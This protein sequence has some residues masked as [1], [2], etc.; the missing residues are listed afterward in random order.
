[1]A[2]AGRLAACPVVRRGVLE[3][4]MVKLMRVWP[5]VA[6]MIGAGLTAAGAVRSAA[7][8]D[9]PA[10]RL[11]VE[12]SSQAAGLS[13]RPPAGGTMIRRAGIG[14]DIVT[15]TN[16]DEKWSLKV[17]Q[18][19]FEKPARLIGWDDPSTPVNEIITNP[20]ILDQTVQQL[21]LQNAATQ[22]LRDDVVNVGPHDTGIL[23]SRSGQGGTN[24]L[25][26][27]A[28]IRIND[29]RYYVFDLT[30]PSGH[31]AADP[32]DAEDPSEAMAVGIFSAILDTVQVLDQRPIQIDN[33]SRLFRTRNLMVNLPARIRTA[34]IE[35]QFFR[36]LRDGKDVGWSYQAE[37]MGKRLGQEGVFVATLSHGRPDE[38]TVI[39][40][41]SEMFSILDFRKA[42][43]TWVTVN[44]IARDGP[45]QTITEIGQ[46]GRK[47]KPVFEQ[48]PADAGREGGPQLVRMS[49]TYPL[50]VTQTTA[51]GSKQST[52]ELP[53]F[54]LPAAI[55]SMLPR[56]VPLNEARGYLFGVWVPSEQEVIY[57]Y[58]DVEAPREVTFGGQQVRAVAIRD[59]IGLEGEP[60]FH[61]LLPN[62]SYLGSI[63]PST[64]LTIV[65]TDIQTVTRL[66]PDARIV[67]PN[68]LDVPQ[69]TPAR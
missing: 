24:W 58:I 13:F 62:G 48:R 59:R 18:L 68:L 29:H 69:E 50:N 21:K 12:F 40:V 67:R 10:D 8:D 28:F 3:Q 37:E 52:R 23:I 32:P 56:L 44:I 41:A 60:T 64:S 53:V 17:S 63:T 45:R 16:A 22:I 20:G 33:D 19:Y 6:L 46:S 7:A 36:V 2:G 15:Y 38:Q 35:E 49:E 34:A 4:N 42:D 55:S 25:R 39:D 43:E 26:Q 1:M 11:G 14:R 31:T 30:T 61:Y 54:Y 66:W 5:L 27:Q 51:A 57:R 47:A 9:S 65:A